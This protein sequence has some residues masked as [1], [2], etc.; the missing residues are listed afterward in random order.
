[1]YE[2]FY[3]VVTKSQI[4]IAKINTG[5]EDNEKHFEIYL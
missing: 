2:V 1:M 3:R 5:N 4:H